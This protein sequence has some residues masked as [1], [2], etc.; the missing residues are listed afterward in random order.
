MWF[1]H[2]VASIVLATALGVVTG[3]LRTRVLILKGYLVGMEIPG[4]DSY[5]EH[6]IKLRKCTSL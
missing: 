5:G 1:Y 4:N 6:F 2:V 3:K